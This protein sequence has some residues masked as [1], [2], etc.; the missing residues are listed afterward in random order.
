MAQSGGARLRAVVDEGIDTRAMHTTK[1][2]IPGCPPVQLCRRAGA[3]PA[4]PVVTFTGRILR[5]LQKYEKKNRK[6]NERKKPSDLYSYKL[7][8]RTIRII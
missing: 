3:G 7:L 1:F 4:R 8:K 5:L 2:S 6:K